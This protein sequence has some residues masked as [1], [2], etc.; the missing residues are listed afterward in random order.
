MFQTSQIGFPFAPRHTFST[1]GKKRDEYFHKFEKD[2]SLYFSPLSKLRMAI[3]QWVFFF[4]FCGTLTPGSARVPGIRSDLIDSLEFSDARAFD[5][6]GRYHHE[7][8]FVRLPQKYKSTVRES[9]WNLSQN[10][11]GISIRFRTN[12]PTIVVRCTVMNDASLPHM[13][14]TGVKGVDLYA[15]NGSDWQYVKT[16][17]PRGKVSEY[18]LLSDGDGVA[19]EYLLNLPLYDGV[20]SLEIGVKPGSEITKAKERLLLEKKP[21]VY[22]GTSI[23]QGGCASR[24]GLAYTNILSRKLDRPFINL[25]FSGNG[26]IETSV[27]EAMAEVDAALYVI[28]CNPNTKDDVIYE[29]TIALVQMLKERRPGI[30]I[31]LVEG[32]LNESNFFNPG[33]NQNIG[34]KNA[35]LRRAFEWLKKKGV[36]GLSYLAGGGLIGE[37]HEATVDGIHPNDIGM[38]RMADALMPAIKKL[39]KN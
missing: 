19:R 37:D 10:S 23:A 22:Y 12:S 18:V 35:E 17:F 38:M 16:G 26:T 36:P 11:A 39:C 32:F 20:E 1:G 27:G 13:P 8:N 6:I 24:P 29:R 14:A 21:V 30:P 2:P 28:D 4:L 31:L 34:K 5:V 33:G 25:G 15:F 7:N 3:R 9:V